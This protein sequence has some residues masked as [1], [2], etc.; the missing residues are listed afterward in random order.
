MP[1]STGAVAASR[2]ARRST[3]AGG[4][5]A[6]P[7]LVHCQKQTGQSLSET[8]SVTSDLPQGVPQTRRYGANAMEFGELLFPC[9]KNNPGVVAQRGEVLVAKRGRHAGGEVGAGTPWAMVRVGSTTRLGTDFRIRE[10][11]QGNNTGELGDGLDSGEKSAQQLLQMSE[12][13]LIEKNPE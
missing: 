4:T 12:K 8:R 11:G 13:W 6:P 3:A 1:I 9:K 10:T 7:A 5:G 2:R